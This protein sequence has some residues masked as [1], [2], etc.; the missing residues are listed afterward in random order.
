MK[1]S[2]RKSAIAVAVVTA[3]VSGTV[4]AQ[5]NTTN[6]VTDVQMVKKLS[7]SKTLTINSIEGGILV[8]GSITVNSSSIAVVDDKQS[9]TLNQGEN[10]LLQNTATGGDEVMSAAS[11][12][13]GLNMASGDNNLQDNAAALTSLNGGTTNGLID[14]EV[15]VRQET[16]G[17][18]TSNLG[19]EN[20]ASLGNNA[21]AT[22]GGNI[23]V[24]IATG[25]NNLQKN[26]M[27]MSVGNGVISEASVNTEQRVQNNITTNLP[28]EAA[29]AG[30]PG[31]VSGQIQLV[32]VTLTATTPAAPGDTGGIT[33]GRFTTSSM[34]NYN[35]NE[36]GTFQGAFSGSYQGTHNGLLSYTTNSAVNLGGVITGQVPVWVLESCGTTCG[37]TVVVK[38]KNTTSLGT[39]AFMGA[40]GNIGIN[41][42]SGT[43]NVQSNSLSMAVI[44][45]P[46]SAPT[47]AQSPAQGLSSTFIP[48]RR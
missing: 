47:V 24:N 38:T 13:I 21:F 14:S 34:G 6:N 23:G 40:I 17:N 45:I 3:A 39:G 42:S 33:G 41:M 1:T 7:L 35:G 22:A 30:T 27:A 48:I 36:N 46:A 20:T 44:P 25:N 26:N 18:L 43:N 8:N 11:G 28:L 10:Y 31:Q 19:V 12:D 16:D 2:F 32:D 9:A 15:I 4:V 37:D 29:G 5:G